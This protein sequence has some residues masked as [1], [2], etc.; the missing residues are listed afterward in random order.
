MSHR[1]EIKDLTVSYNRV[2]AVHHLNLD[3]ACGTCVALVGPNGAGK[4][5][6]LKTLAGLLQPETGTIRLHGRDL[7][8]LRQDMAYLPQ[9]EN[10]DWDFPVTVRGLADMG[11]YGRVG[12]W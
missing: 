8:G 1:L 10:V 7:R 4:T 5:T 9:R 6:L 3:L 12:W 11:R 2:P